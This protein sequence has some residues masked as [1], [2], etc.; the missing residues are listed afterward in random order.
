[1]GITNTISE[2]SNYFYQWHKN[3]YDEIHNVTI[4]TQQTIYETIFGQGGIQE[5]LNTLVLNFNNLLNRYNTL[6]ANSSSTIKNLETDINANKGDITWLKNNK[7]DTNKAIQKESTGACWNHVQLA[8]NPQLNNSYPTQLWYN[9]YLG[10]G[11]LY[12]DLDANDRR[13]KRPVNKYGYTGFFEFTSV[14][15]KYGNNQYQRYIIDEGRKPVSTFSCLSTN[16]INKI[17]LEPDGKLYGAFRETA[18]VNNKNGVLEA[19]F[20]MMYFYN[21]K[22]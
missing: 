2:L 1:M 16:G 4:T 12:C 8:Y 14:V 17:R 6:T 7:I 19:R 13:A 15:N 20:V 18:A 11:V 9:D 10:I 3:K 5:T 21:S 22:K